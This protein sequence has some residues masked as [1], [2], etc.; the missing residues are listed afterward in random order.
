M[1]GWQQLWFGYAASGP[2]GDDRQQVVAS[3]PG[4]LDDPAVDTL[5]RALC[6][7]DVDDWPAA[8][9]HGATQSFG[10]TDDEAL[11][12]VFCRSP[13]PR[14]RAGRCAAHI[15]VGPRSAGSAADVLRLFDS[16]TWWRGEPLDA[17]LRESGGELPEITFEEFDPVPVRRPPQPQVSEEDLAGLAQ[18]VLSSAGTAPVVLPQLPP[19]AVATMVALAHHVP[20]LADLVRFSTHEMGPARQWFDVVGSDPAGSPPDEVTVSRQLASHGGPQLGAH[21]LGDVETMLAQ[22]LPFVIARHGGLDRS[23]RDLFFRAVDALVHHH[24]DGIARLLNDPRSLPL[25]VGSATGREVAAASLWGHVRP[26]WVHGKQALDGR[27][28]EL[29]E[30]GALTWRVRPPGATPDEISD[31]WSELAVVDAEAETGFVRAV[32]HEALTARLLGPPLPGRLVARVV[33]SALESRLDADLMGRLLDVAAD[34]TDADLLTSQLV[35]VGLRVRL[36][37]LGLSRGTLTRKVL[38]ASSARDAHL[39]QQLLGADIDDDAVDAILGAVEPEEAAALVAASIH[40]MGPSRALRSLRLVEADLGSARLLNVV[41][42][43]RSVVALPLGPEDEE[44]VTGH[45]A[46]AAGTAGAHHSGGPDP[47]TELPWDLARNLTSEAASAWRQTA[48]LVRP[49]VNPTPEGLLEQFE[50]LLTRVGDERDRHAIA[51]VGVAKCLLTAYTADHVTEI[52]D[53]LATRQG[54]EV[55]E[56]TS[57]LLTCAERMFPYP[58]RSAIGAILVHIGRTST[59]RRGLKRKAVLLDEHQLRAEALAARLT[60]Y[61]WREVIRQAQGQGP[62]CETWVRG[63]KPAD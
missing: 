34:H 13:I 23:R 4:L 37:A 33:R 43:L 28:D 54:L 8:Q 14:R 32:L 42:A 39:A 17:A 52:V 1:T 40:T 63:L 44:W 60:R 5:V 27:S 56:Q 57:V 36:A 18:A 7:H 22:V 58:G 26:R 41:E 55:S 10:W 59:F 62:A 12:F 9:R 47:V 2:E 20:S 48:F 46:R 21:L 51:M 25:L 19:H 24:Q 38:A 11:R 3:T 15:L 45:F 53:R 29:R 50:L 61:Q 16:P 35:P 30:L 49:R 31:V 6:R